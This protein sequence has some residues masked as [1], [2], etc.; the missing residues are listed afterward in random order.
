MELNPQTRGRL[1]TI[2]MTTEKGCLTVTEN[3]R[4]TMKI[5]EK[6]FLIKSVQKSPQILR[7]STKM[8]VLA[9]ECLHHDLAL[10]IVEVG[11]PPDRDRAHALGIVE[12][13]LHPSQNLGL[14]L[15]IAEVDLRPDQGPR[16]VLA[17]AEEELLIAQPMEQD[18]DRGIT[19][20]VVPIVHPDLDLDLV[21]EASPHSNMRFHPEVH[22]DHNMH[23]HL[24]PP[25]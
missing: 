4:R 11:L 23:V 24:A 15:A 21:Q 7:L 6:G 1:L 19:H 5:A 16:L 22:Q 12:V 17:I 18:H 2:T 3:S 25:E 8:K 10:G 14:A 9:K 13:G 20:M